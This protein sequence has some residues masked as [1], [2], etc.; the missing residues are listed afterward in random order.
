MKESLQRRRQALL[1]DFDPTLLST[2]GN[3]NNPLASHNHHHALPETVDSILLNRNLISQKNNN[4]KDPRNPSSNLPSGGGA[5]GGGSSTLVYK[6]NPLRRRVRIGRQYQKATAIGSASS[7][8][9]YP[10]K[11]SHHSH[12]HHHVCHQHHHRSCRKYKKRNMY[13]QALLQNWASKSP[14][15]SFPNAFG[16]V[17]RDK[18]RKDSTAGHL[19]KTPPKTS[20]S[21]STTTAAAAIVA[22]NSSNG[23]IAVA[24]TE[25]A[26]SSGEIEKKY[27]GHGIFSRLKSL[28]SSKASFP[29]Q[30][31]ANNTIQGGTTGSDSRWRPHTT[32]TT[33]RF[34][35]VDDSDEEL[36]IFE[37]SKGNFSKGESSTSENRQEDI[38]SKNRAMK[39]SAAEATASSLFLSETSIPGSNSMSFISTNNSG[40]VLGDTNH[41]S[42]N[43][44]NNNNSNE[45]G[46]YLIGQQ[47]TENDS[48]NYNSYNTTTT[49]VDNQKSL[50]DETTT[51]SLESNKK[52]SKG[53]YSLVHDDR[54]SSNIINGNEKAAEKNSC[55]V[56]VSS[57]NNTIFQDNSHYSS[58]SQ[59]KRRL[60]IFKKSGGSMLQSL[61]FQRNLKS[62]GGSSSNSNN[63]NN[64]DNSRPSTGPQEPGTSSSVAVAESASPHPP[65]RSRSFVSAGRLGSVGRNFSLKKWRKFRSS[66]TT[67][68]NPP[69]DNNEDDDNN[70]DESF[71]SCQTFSACSTCDFAKSSKVLLDA[72]DRERESR[73]HTNHR[74]YTSLFSS[75][76]TSNL[77]HLNRS[78]KESL[79]RQS[80]PINKGETSTG[81]LLN[82]NNNNVDDPSIDSNNNNNSGGGI[83]G[84]KFSTIRNTYHNNKQQGQQQQQQYQQPITLDSPIKSSY[85]LMPNILSR[86]VYKRMASLTRKDD[87]DLK[88]VN[89]DDNNDDAED[90]KD[91]SDESLLPK[92][93]LKDPSSWER[94][95][96]INYE[97]L[98]LN[99]T[100][101]SDYQSV[102]S[103]IGVE[104]D[105][106]KNEANDK[107]KQ[108]FSNHRHNQRGKQ[109]TTATKGHQH[110]IMNS[111]LMAGIMNKNNLK[112]AGNLV[113]AAKGCAKD[114]DGIYRNNTYAAATSSADNNGDEESANDFR[115][116]IKFSGKLDEYRRQQ[117]NENNRMIK[118]DLFSHKNNNNKNTQISK[119]ENSPIASSSTTTSTYQKFKTQFGNNI[120]SRN[121]QYQHHHHQ[122]DIQKEKKRKEFE[123]KGDDDRFSI[124]TTPE[125]LEKF[126]NDD[127]KKG[128]KGEEEEGKDSKK[129]FENEYHHHHNNNHQINQQQSN[130]NNVSS[131]YSSF[132]SSPFLNTYNNNNDIKKKSKWKEGIKKFGIRNKKVFDSIDYNNNIQEEEEQENNK[133]TVIKNDNTTKIPLFNQFDYNNN[134]N[135]NTNTNN[136]N[137]TTIKSIKKL[138]QDSY[139]QYAK[140]QGQKY[141]NLKTW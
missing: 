52:F 134:D 106:N 62:G 74:Y 88:K 139:K 49:N 137:D 97:M 125:I 67:T 114:V 33:R 48:R 71:C 54:V 45:D 35:L 107:N 90:Q 51:T 115:N 41:D 5:V 42:S 100:V 96:S 119:F 31:W 131:S 50:P 40:P 101:L 65:G 99:T 22:A 136:N 82:E 57:N 129:V 70:E 13:Q 59:S 1:K 75:N 132:S 76:K 120:F 112:F 122:Q 63:N 38:E 58:N 32:T 78:T 26:S 141:I 110:N 53:K 18:K 14:F 109:V 72:K 128:E 12:H 118:F 47:G 133:T 138:N 123:E 95:E 7:H 73:R 11:H 9:R 60:S 126:P 56:V 98:I 36:N 77:F 104:S 108:S 116:K 117:K 81:I 6:A 44:N 46:G 19:I 91:R 92:I 24:P 84:V 27:I 10:R 94:L 39:K 20:T 79:R 68:Q 37:F 61:T 3:N 23:G 124:S 43:N 8:R 87:F 102:Y 21:L 80:N 29:N 64:D 113:A 103:G 121:D 16:L 34:K 105:N 93:N 28:K 69:Q 140:Q 83:S 127:I 111:K 30:N 15:L 66:T 135:N 85:R 55:R 89:D 4:L 86:G 25:D 17:S 2:V 130:N